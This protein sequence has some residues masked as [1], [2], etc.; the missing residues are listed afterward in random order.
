M[1]VFDALHAT[2]AAVEEGIVAGGGVALMRASAVLSGLKVP[3]DEQ[4]GVDIIR[5]AAWPDLHGV[6]IRQVTKAKLVGG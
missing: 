2:H 3:G 5:R 1:E 4:I 6:G